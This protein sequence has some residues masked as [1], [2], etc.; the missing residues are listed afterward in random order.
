MHDKDYL[1]IKSLL[2][3]MKEEISLLLPDKA[4]VSYI[5]HATGKKQDTIIAFVKRNYEPEIDWWKENNK[6]TVSRP[7]MKALLRRYKNV[8]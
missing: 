5:A 7:I 8:A 1:E 6:I 3:D 2:L 4:T